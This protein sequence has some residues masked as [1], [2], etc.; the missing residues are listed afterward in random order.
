MTPR[1]V[2]SKNKE[3]IF[4]CFFTFSLWEGHPI[5][6]LKIGTVG[7]DDNN[8]E[9]IKRKMMRKFINVL[10]VMAVMTFGL[11][12][13]GS[14]DDVP[15]E[16]Q[17]T[18]E[19]MVTVTDVKKTIV[20]ELQT[21]PYHELAFVSKNNVEKPCLV[22]YLHGGSSRG[23]DN[24]TQM[25]EAGI[26]SISNYL[27]AHHKNAMFLVP[28]CPAGGAWL[29]PAQ[30]TLRTLVAQYVDEDKVDAK[31]I[32][33]FGGSMGG[34]GTWGML[35]AYPDLFAAAMPVAADPS[36]V[37]DYT[38][39]TPVFTVMGTADVIMNLET[40]HVFVENLEAQGIETRFEIGE[41]W[42]HEVTCI[43]SYTTQRLD[44]VFSH[45]RN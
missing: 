22:L 14:D 8:I 36:K 40:A 9:N 41:G 5:V 31:Q 32:Y 18:P 20:T 1:I 27:K 4:C 19:E 42:T 2:K 44:W 34:T 23:D 24:E 11:T 30:A 3:R 10:F 21:I 15:G 28:Q 45:K 12:A 39:K 17:K 7:S 33:I 16:P 38:S 6:V 35:A 26:D 43:E 13:C 37:G 29:G 25:G